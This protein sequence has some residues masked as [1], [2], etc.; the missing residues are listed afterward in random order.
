MRNFLRLA[1]AGV[2]DGTT[3]HRVVHGFVIQ[4][5]MVSTRSAPLTQKQQARAHAAAGV[6]RHRARGG[7][8]LDGAA[9]D[10]ASAS[11]SFFIV[12]RRRAVA[13]RQVQRVRTG[14]R[15]MALVDAIE[16]TPVQGDAPVTRI[17]LKQ[18]RVV[19]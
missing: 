12:H 14:R 16:Q 10:P 18:V 9:D 13:R 4:T 6:Q 8:G 15:G 1:S 3:F 7:H 5:G 17:E 11:T 2:Y 19:K